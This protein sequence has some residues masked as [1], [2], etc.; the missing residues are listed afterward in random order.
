LVVVVVIYGAHAAIAEAAVI[1][2]EQQDEPCV[3][4]TDGLQERDVKSYIGVEPEHG[5][6]A[7]L[8]VPIVYTG[9]QSAPLID[10]QFA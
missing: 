5:F 4:L 6:V 1:P 10:K 8:V 9:W 3:C 2:I 7:V